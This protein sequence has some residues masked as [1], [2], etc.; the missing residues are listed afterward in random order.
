MIEI[1]D[2]CS[3]LKCTRTFKAECEGWVRGERDR[4]RGRVGGGRVGMWACGRGRERERERERESGSQRQR[5]SQP[6][7]E[8]ECLDV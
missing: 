5:Q 3:W 7:R 8:R 1:E 2:A 6:E 4:R